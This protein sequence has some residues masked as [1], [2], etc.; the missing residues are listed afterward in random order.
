MTHHPRDARSA[1]GRRVM[2][3]A[4]CR[5]VVP[6]RAASGWP[7]RAWSPGHR[8][9]LRLLCGTSCEV[10]DAAG[11]LG[12]LVQ[13][14]TGAHP[15]GGSRPRSAA[16]GPQPGSRTARMAPTRR[17]GAVQ[18]E[19][20]PGSRGFSGRRGP[21]RQ[22]RTGPQHPRRSGS[23]HPCGPGDG[24]QG[25]TEAEGHHDDGHHR[26]LNSSR[27]R[28]AEQRSAKSTTCAGQAMRQC[29]ALGLMA[30]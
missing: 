28:Q 12:V 6:G 11:D 15:V 13:V 9:R 21:L 19:T 14:V 2:L 25:K 23:Q 8:G 1:I 26:L 10:G 7:T 22:R 29:A 17:C 30:G 4:G 16:A 3:V 18:P 24:W 5:A 20:P 27:P